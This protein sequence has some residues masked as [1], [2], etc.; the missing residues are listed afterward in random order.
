MKVEAEG[1]WWRMKAEGVV[2]VDG[3]RG[4]GGGGSRLKKDTRQKLFGVIIGIFKVIG[5]IIILK[6]CNAIKRR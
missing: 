6:R 2:V 4:G 5:L 3:G 1:W